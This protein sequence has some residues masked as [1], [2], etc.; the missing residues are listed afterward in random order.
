MSPE[1]LLVLSLTS[2]FSEPIAPFIK[3]K[4]TESAWPCSPSN[5]RHKILWRVSV[6]HI[7]QATMGSPTGPFSLSDPMSRKPW[8]LAAFQAIPHLL[9]PLAKCAHFWGVS[10]NW[11]LSPEALILWHLHTSSSQIILRPAHHSQ[12][13]PKSSS[14]SRALSSCRSRASSY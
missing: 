11:L 12:G 6:A 1:P 4:Y 7:R 2:Y 3:S 8:P 13:R 10:F 5:N 9:G 14:T